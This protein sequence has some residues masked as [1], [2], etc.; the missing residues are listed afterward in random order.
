MLEI[1]DDT[2]EAEVV[3][4]DK[5]VVLDFS[6]VWCGP[7]KRLAPIME[8]LAKEYAGKV[9]IAKMDI[10]N[11]PQT[12]AKFRV[13]SVPTVVFFKGGKPVDMVVG[14]T[15]KENLKKKIDPLLQ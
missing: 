1:N 15:G 8:E 13:M 9:K 12:P 5:P 10:D 6:A 7:C 2:F 4:S 3:K 11:S 14:L